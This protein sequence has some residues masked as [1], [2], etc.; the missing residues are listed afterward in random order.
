MRTLGGWC[1]SLKAG[2]EEGGL[3]PRKDTLG[4]ALGSGP[5]GTNSECNPPQLSAE[6]V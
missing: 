4:S 2:K 5:A 1:S 6:D 3:N